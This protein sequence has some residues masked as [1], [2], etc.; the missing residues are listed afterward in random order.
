MHSSGTS[1]VRILPLRGGF[2]AHVG[3]N[4]AFDGLDPSSHKSS[5]TN[6]TTGRCKLVVNLLCSVTSDNETFEVSVSP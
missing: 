4:E 1:V 5:Q 2:D 3:Y 6:G